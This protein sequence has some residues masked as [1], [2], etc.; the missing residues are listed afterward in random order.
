MGR[1]RAKWRNKDMNW[2]LL[3][4]NKSITEVTH[5]REEG[6]RLNVKGPAPREIM[7]A[8]PLQL[9]KATRTVNIRTFAGK[10]L[11]P[12]W[13]VWYNACEIGSHFIGFNLYIYIPWLQST[14]WDFKL[15]Y[16]Y[17]YLLWLLEGPSKITTNH[18]ESTNVRKDERQRIPNWTQFCH[19][20]CFLP[21]SSSRSSRDCTFV[22]TSLYISIRAGLIF[23]IGYA[24]IFEWILCRSSDSLSNLKKPFGMR[25]LPYLISVLSALLDSSDLAKSPLA[26]FSSALSLA[27]SRSISSFLWKWWCLF[28]KLSSI[29]CCNSY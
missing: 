22:V 2:L 10:A 3:H 1:C 4:Y 27:A 19:L 16:I 17:F 6:G 21:S 13:V 26:S 20:L 7:V 28:F 25:C 9:S 5:V 8:D 14:G 15:F 24:F 23:D 18:C 29:P 12:S 11:A